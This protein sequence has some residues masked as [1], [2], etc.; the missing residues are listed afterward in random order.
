MSSGIDPVEYN[1]LVK[2]KQ[3]EEKT[4]GGLFIPDD[5]KEREQY[6]MTEGVLV[7]ASPA[8]FTF[9]YEGWPDEGRVPQVGDR[10]L[11]ARYQ[12][13]EVKGVDGD[14]YWLMKDK[15]IAGVMK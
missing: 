15:S 10:V 4:A 9:N 3:V 1:V 12:A 8:A 11:F 6:A 14:T 13:T 2:P 5:T 7:A